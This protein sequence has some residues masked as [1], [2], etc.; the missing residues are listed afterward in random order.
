MKIW[1]IKD[2]LTLL[3]NVEVFC[4]LEG[5]TFDS[6]KRACDAPCWVTT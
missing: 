6:R 4:V 5:F 1:L 2:I 3:L